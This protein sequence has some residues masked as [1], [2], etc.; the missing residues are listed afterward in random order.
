MRASI[1]GLL[2][3]LCAT[4]AALAIEPVKSRP[5]VEV[6]T[7]K[8]DLERRRRDPVELHLYGL[9]A[10]NHVAQSERVKNTNVIRDRVHFSDGSTASFFRR[11]NRL[12]GMATTDGKTGERVVS[13]ES[14]SLM[15]QKQGQPTRIDLNVKQLP[16]PK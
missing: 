1:A 14:G 2:I 13:S 6:K 12:A 11:G 15:V 8:P 4:S 9:S 5:K 7:W 10:E 3:S 16:L